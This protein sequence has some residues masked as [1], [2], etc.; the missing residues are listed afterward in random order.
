M[1]DCHLG[2]SPVNVSRKPITL[3]KFSPLKP[4]LSSF[5][6]ILFILTVFPLRV[7]RISLC[8]RKLQPSNDKSL[9]AM[10][11]CFASEEQYFRM[12]KGP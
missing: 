2:V 8:R 1:S 9:F 5:D 4:G 7:D 12:K 3:L 10:W 11:V 6:L